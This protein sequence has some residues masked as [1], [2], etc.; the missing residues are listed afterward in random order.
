MAKITLVRVRRQIRAKP[1]TSSNP[2]SISADELD[3]AYAMCT[4]GT[5]LF[6]GVQKRIDDKLFRPAYVAI[7]PSM[8]AALKC[9][10]V[11]RKINRVSVPQSIEQLVSHVE[12]ASPQ[13]QSLFSIQMKR[14]DRFGND[15]Y[16]KVN[17]WAHA[18]PEMW[19]LYKNGHEIRLVLNPLGNMVSQAQSEL[20]KYVPGLVDA[21]GHWVGRF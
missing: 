19:D 4:H 13:L 3:W 6:A 1:P 10:W 21:N 20:S 14:K 16:R 5:Y 11:L 18:D 15:C 2:L 9:L 8:E 7:R 17:G 12:A